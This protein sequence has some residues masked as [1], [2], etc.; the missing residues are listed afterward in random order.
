MAGVQYD[1]FI[2]DSRQA[3]AIVDEFYTTLTKYRTPGAPAWRNRVDQLGGII[4]LV[5]SGQP[6]DLFV[7]ILFI[8]RRNDGFVGEDII[9]PGRT[10]GAGKPDPA[11]L[12][13][14]RTACKDRQPRAVRIAHQ[15][16]QDIDPVTA[17]QVNSRNGSTASSSLRMCADNRVIKASR[18]VQSAAASLR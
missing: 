13:R 17:D 12:D 1:A 9:H 8:S 4:G 18:S 3:T 10:E 2:S 14:R 6:Q 15:I 7:I 16:D 5:G 11:D